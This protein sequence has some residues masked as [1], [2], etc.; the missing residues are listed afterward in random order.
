MEKHL[1]KNLYTVGCLF[2][3]I[4]G[5]SLAFRKTGFNILWANDID[6]YASQVYRYNFPDVF[7]I[8]KDVREIT[9]HPEPV[10]I[11]T[12]GFPCQPFSIAGKKG[13]FD[14]PRGQLFFEIIRLANSFGKAKPKILLLE[15]VKHLVSHNKGKTFE[16]VLESIDK[17]GYWSNAAILNTKI[18]TRIPHNRERVFIIA[19]NKD[20]FNSNEFRFPRNED[21]TDPITDYLDLDHKAED[22]FYYDPKDK[23][24]D[25]LYRA[26]KD[27]KNHTVCQLRRN[28]V[29][30]N[31]T[32]SVPTLTANM[33]M[34][35]HNVPVIKDRW[36]IRKLTPKECLRLQGFQDNEFSFPSNLAKSHRYRL[37]G[38]S[39]TVALVEK[40][41]KECLKMLEAEKHADAQ[42]LRTATETRTYQTF[43]YQ[44]QIYTHTP[45]RSYR[46]NRP[47]ILQPGRNL[48]CSFENEDRRIMNETNT[49]RS[50]YHPR[51]L[52]SM[53]LYLDR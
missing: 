29:R 5:F 19:L 24:G 4:G 33:G 34:G 32:E 22:E 16:K 1:Q 27:D 20:H 17:A 8:E 13:G 53:P 38:N 2:S 44:N 25:L 40:L 3:G 6:P 26:M 42:D 52:V 10:D 46:R 9:A 35:G 49:Y 36:G 23:Y 15:N 50:H 45:L 37:V 28:C 21:N 47:P 12:A 11:I 31:K 30:K 43:F 7:F 18:H 51:C 39:V 14:D 41:A 48:H